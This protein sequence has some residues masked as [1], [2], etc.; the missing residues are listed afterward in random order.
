MKP[1][2]RLGQLCPA[3]W[4][5]CADVLT[6]AGFSKV[7]ELGFWEE[8]GDHLALLLSS[9]TGLPLVSPEISLESPLPSLR[10][11]SR[12]VPEGKAAGPG[13]LTLLLGRACCC[14]PCHPALYT[15]WELRQPALVGEAGSEG[16]AS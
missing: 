6:E 14:L 8:P 12:Q 2:L 9:G 15:R 11:P 13:S 10:A 7:L 5:F 3:S 4:G 1:L 16:P